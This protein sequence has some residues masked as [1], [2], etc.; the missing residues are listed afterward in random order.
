MGTA[1]CRARQPQEAFIMRTFTPPAGTRFYAGVD[2]PSPG[3]APV[4]M[5][6]KPY[7]SLLLQI[8]AVLIAAD[9]LEAQNDSPTRL[10]SVAKKAC[11]R[12][13]LI[14]SDFEED[15]WSPSQ[16]RRQ[17]GRQLTKPCRSLM[18]RMVYFGA[19]PTS[20]ITSFCAG[21]L[22]ESAGIS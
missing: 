19:S 20:A 15:R 18:S 17:A 13:D 12:C 9:R 14:S 21:T 7:L 8:Q 11:R 3:P 10:F 1:R 6:A 22:K 16:Q 2:L 4:V 5:S